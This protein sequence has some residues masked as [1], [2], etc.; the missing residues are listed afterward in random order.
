[1]DRLKIIISQP[2]MTV[3]T[4]PFLSYYNERLTEE[5]G[6]PNAEKVIQMRFLPDYEINLIYEVSAG[7]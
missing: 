7:L 6:A 1:M 3:L 4:T 5:I 2:S